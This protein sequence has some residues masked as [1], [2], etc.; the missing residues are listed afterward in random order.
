MNIQQKI[1]EEYASDLEYYA[2]NI[3]SATERHKKILELAHLLPDISDLEL[4]NE[5]SY[6]SFYV[7]EV[8]LQIP[9]NIA[10][11]DEI[12]KRL[13][14]LGWTI[15]RIVERRPE[16]R[17]QRIYFVHDEAYNFDFK[18]SMSAR[19][20]KLDGQACELKQIGTREEV[21]TVPIYEVICDDPAPIGD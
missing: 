3:K 18:L 6:L 1:Y 12:S 19:E 4:S 7:Y 5:S 17:S 16:D 10:L 21:R 14:K 8:E 15:D 13:D 2:N 20:N 9:W 11:A